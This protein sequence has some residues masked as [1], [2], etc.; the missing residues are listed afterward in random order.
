MT[1]KLSKDIPDPDGVN[2]PLRAGVAYA[3]DSTYEWAGRTWYI[4]RDE[5]DVPRDVDGRDTLQEFS[6]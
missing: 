5:N 1:I 4:V 3:I 6:M 2:P